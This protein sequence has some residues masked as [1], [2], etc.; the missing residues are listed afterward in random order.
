MQAATPNTEEAQA[1]GQQP[2][3]TC[4]SCSIGFLTAEE[5]SENP[6]YRFLNIFLTL[7][8]G[9][10]YRSDHHRYNMKRRVAS[11][12]PVSAAVFNQKVIERRQETAIMSSLKG[13]SCEICKYV[14]FLRQACSGTDVRLKQNI[15]YGECLSVA[16]KLEEAQGDRTQS[17]L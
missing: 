10:H 3:Y 7:L 11:L 8:T 15:H 16:Y 5:Q 2:L 4:L 17:C 12:P 14:D 1:S 13:S 6:S 9:V